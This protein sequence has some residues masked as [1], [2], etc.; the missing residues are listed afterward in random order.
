MYKYLLELIKIRSEFKE[1]MS[2]ERALNFDQWK[3]FSEN[4]KP[5]RV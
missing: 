4:Y 5:L 1:N 2:R 3:L